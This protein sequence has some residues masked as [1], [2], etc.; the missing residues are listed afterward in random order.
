MVTQNINNNSHNICTSE[1]VPLKFCVVTPI[2]VKGKQS[3]SHNERILLMLL[4]SMH[5]KITFC[6]AVYFF[7]STYSLIRYFW[8]KSQKT[9][10]ECFTNHSFSLLYRN[11]KLLLIHISLALGLATSFLKYT[12][13]KWKHQW[14]VK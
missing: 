3:T 13:H 7:R 1:N 14:N 2:N 10:I 11:W 9:N 4:H 8:S 6:T 12:L 5:M